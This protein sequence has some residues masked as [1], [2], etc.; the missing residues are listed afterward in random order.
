LIDGLS[1]FE[2]A[3]TAAVFVP[4]FGLLMKIRRRRQYNI[5]G[6]STTGKIV[7]KDG[8]ATGR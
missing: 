3:I 2:L 6:S 7:M 5:A 4:A 8:V 1:I